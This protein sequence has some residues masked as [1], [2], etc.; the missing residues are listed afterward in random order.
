MRPNTGILTSDE[1]TLI[2]YCFFHFPHAST[3]FVLLYELFRGENSGLLSHLWCGLHPRPYL[4]VFWLSVIVGVVGCTCVVIQSVEAN[5]AL[6][7]CEPRV[8]NR[9]MILH[10][11]HNNIKLVGSFSKLKKKKVIRDKEINDYYSPLC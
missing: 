9:K 2:F 5:F 10:E 4:V 11:E 3:S 7:Y 6:I 8:T 1:I